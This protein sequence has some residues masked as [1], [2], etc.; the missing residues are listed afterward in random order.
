MALNM[1]LAI[2]Y[3]HTVMM[4]AEIKSFF[5]FQGRGSNSG[6]LFFYFFIWNNVGTYLFCQCLQCYRSCK[7]CR[8]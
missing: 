5:F 1:F 6:E 7:W 2:F 8:V 3:V 4:S